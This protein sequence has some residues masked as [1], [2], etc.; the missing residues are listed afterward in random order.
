MQTHCDPIALLCTLQP[1]HTASE[2]TAAQVSRPL[3]CKKSHSNTGT[4]NGSN[5]LSLQTTTEQPSFS[6]LWCCYRR[7]CRTKKGTN[8]QVF[9]LNDLIPGLC[10]SQSHR[11]QHDTES[12]PTSDYRGSLKTVT[13]TPVA[14]PPVALLLHTHRDKNWSS[15]SAKAH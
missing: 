10:K 11:C 15:S 4:C 1:H 5:L 14:L 12:H 13:A 7:R 6:A 3:G 9:Y 2:V 8:L